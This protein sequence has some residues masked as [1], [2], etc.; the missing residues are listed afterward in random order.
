MTLKDLNK[1]EKGAVETLAGGVAHDF[2]NLL[3]A[4]QGRACLMLKDLKPSH[5][6]YRH[7]SEII[8]SVNKGAEI[9]GQ[10]LG[11]ARAGKYHV[12]PIELNRL[13]ISSL[14]KLALSDKGIKL[15]TDLSEDSLICEVDQHQIRLVLMNVLENAVVAMPNGGELTVVTESARIVN[16]SAESRGLKPGKFAKITVSDTGVGMDKETLQRVFD[17]FYTTRCMGDGHGKGL[18][19]AASH[20]IIRNHGGVI[21][22]WSTVNVGTSFSIIL[23]QLE[24]SDRLDCGAHQEEMLMGFE[25]ILLVDDEEIILE[26]G[27]EV[28]E[29][30]GYRVATAISGDAAVEIFQSGEEFD[31]VVLDMIMPGMDG[32]ETFSRLQEINPDV[33]VLISTGHTIDSAAEGMLDAGCK[34]FILKPFSISAFSYKLREVLES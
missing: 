2:N 30:L 12:E 8:R 1:G 19:L 27:R 34:G 33:R 4:I 9:T 31:L 5:P 17:P 10:L 3:M 25:T 20:G 24:E 14:R 15:E 29:E 21:E 6:F 32:P 22:V 7:V 16:S 18:G 11:F 13:V 26:M 28:L 23:S